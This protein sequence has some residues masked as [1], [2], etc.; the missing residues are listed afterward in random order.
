MTYFDTQLVHGQSVGDNSTR[1]VN[2]PIYNSSTF[3]FETVREYPRWDYARSGNP[4]REAVEKQVA[5]LE[6]GIA[7]FAFSSGLAAIHAALSIFDPGDHIITGDNIYGGTYS[8]IHEYFERWGL[9]FSEA[10]TTSE[11]ALEDAFI[12]AQ[13]AGKKVKA[14]YFEVLTNPLLK[15]SDVSVVSR[16]AHK[17]GAIV[18]IDNTFVTPFG[19]QP[20]DAGA[21]IVLHS[22]TKYLSGH[23]DI[24]A[25]VAVTNSEELASKLYFALNRVGGALS[26]QD[27]NL[28]RRGIQTLALRMERHQSNAL[29]VAQRLE[30]NQYVTH[31]NYPGLP[32]NAYHA[33]ASEQLHTF[34]GVLSFEF[35]DRVDAE[36][37]LDSL[38]LFTVAVSLGAVES[39]AE[40]PCRMTHFELPREERL[41]HGITDGLVRLS[42]GIEDV[43]DLI[44]DLDQAIHAA[45]R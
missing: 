35:D 39:L 16:I 29:T 30:N 43:R 37:M 36:K 44:E 42:I 8:I 22:A 10:D 19:Q 21:D 12:S 38:E 23:S 6:H 26:P 34:G 11:Q 20:L 31:V 40:L 4:T 28:L 25:G 15:M 13:Q 9:S 18:I 5:A 2:P 3:A 32:S 1:A 41:K 17:Y 27:C 24:T 7:G 45:L 33:L 14:V